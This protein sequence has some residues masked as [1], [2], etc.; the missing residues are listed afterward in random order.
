MYEPHHTRPI[1]SARFA[2]RIMLHGAVALCIVA[3]SLLIG[4]A[5]YMAT[6]QMGLLDAFLNSSMLLGGMGPVKTEGLS[7]EGKLFAGCYALYAGLV[8]IAVMSIML[9]PV[10][11]RIMH[12]YHWDEKHD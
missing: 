2:L 1:P 4:I 8:F 6:E 3:F 12:R 9:A 10:V 7:P 11:H 5:G